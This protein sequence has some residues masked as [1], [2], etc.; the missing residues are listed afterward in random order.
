M[1]CESCRWSQPRSMLT[2]ECHRY[3]PT[4]EWPWVEAHDWC[5]EFVEKKKTSPVNG[6]VCEPTAETPWGV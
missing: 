3:P 4:G 1:T 6:D 2:Y 5:G